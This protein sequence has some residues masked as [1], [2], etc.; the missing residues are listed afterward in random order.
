MRTKFSSRTS[1]VVI[2]AAFAVVIP[3]VCAGRCLV[4]DNTASSD[5]AIVLSGDAND[6]R[7]QRG[8]NLLRAG[9]THELIIDESTQVL[10][11][12][13][14]FEYARAWSETLP[15]EIGKHVHVCP[16]T[17][18]ST[19]SELRGVGQ[20]VNTIAPSSSR[21]LL[22]TSEYH[23]RRALSIAK[24]LHPHWSWS[25]S[26][27]PDPSFGINWWSQREWAKTCLMEWQKLLWWE[28]VERWKS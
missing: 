22:V 7:L 5:V 25:V 12:R 2:C 6:L 17:G 24:R 13:P 27:V 9:Y 3:L 18:D 10:F 21:F 26:A 4:V 14:V 20:C 28:L 15:P 23:T 16:L 8:L 11:G 19:T 1:I